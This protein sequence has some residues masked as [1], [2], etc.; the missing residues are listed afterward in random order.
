MVRWTVRFPEVSDPAR[1]AARVWPRRCGLKDSRKQERLS[2]MCGRFTLRAP[3]SVVAEQFALFELPPFT[4]RFNIAPSQPVPVVRLAAEQPQP[5]RELVWLR[6]GLI[7]SWAKD[8]AI[9]NRLINA[10]AETAAEKPA[11]RAALRR[12]RCLVAADGF[13]EWQ[14]FGKAKQPYFIHLRGDRPFAF[15]GLWE[16][17]E[18]PDS[19]PIESCTL[20]TTEAN[21]LLR[22]IHNRMPVILPADDYQPWLNPAV[23]RPE[24]LAPLLRPYPAGEMAADPVSTFVNSPA[25]EGPQCIAPG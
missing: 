4:P 1:C 8:P 7:P 6:W 13:Y 10:R 23:E 5:Q 19:S 17:W 11:F 14:R 20:L 21:E 25:N 9:G 12:R 16:S 24:Q 22:P 15:A 2:V 18:G 3:A